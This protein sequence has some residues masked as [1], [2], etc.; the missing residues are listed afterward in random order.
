M[1]KGKF[2]DEEEKKK[3]EKRSTSQRFNLI[4]IGNVILQNF[5]WFSIYHDD[6]NI[7]EQL[8]TIYLQL[9]RIKR[10]ENQWKLILNFLL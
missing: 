6:T 7:L 1:I 5:R 3:M 2:G 8:S 9:K 4:Q 10:V